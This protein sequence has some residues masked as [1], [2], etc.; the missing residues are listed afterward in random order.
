MAATA[1]PQ[2]QQG[3]SRQQVTS[4]SPAAPQIQMRRKILLSSWLTARDKRALW[5]IGGYGIARSHSTYQAHSTIWRA[6]FQ[7]F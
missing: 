2:P 7:N 3:H 4:Q 5:T 6:A 1:D